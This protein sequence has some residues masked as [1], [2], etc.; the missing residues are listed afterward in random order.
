[1]PASKR[2]YNHE[3]AAAYCAANDYSGNAEG[4]ALGVGVAI[5]ADFAV[6]PR[7]GDDLKIGTLGGGQRRRSCT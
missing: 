3:A 4:F 2:R 6:A 1:M 7:S 5:A